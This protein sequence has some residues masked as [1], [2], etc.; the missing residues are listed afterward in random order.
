MEREN[1]IRIAAKADSL[2]MVL[3]NLEGSREIREVSAHEAEKK[4]GGVWRGSAS[5]MEVGEMRSGSSNLSGQERHGYRGREEGR[6]RKANHLL[7]REVCSLGDPTVLASRKGSWPRCE[8][9]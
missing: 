4:G 5:G 7:R 3:G 8:G 2:S 9:V 6:M 1:G